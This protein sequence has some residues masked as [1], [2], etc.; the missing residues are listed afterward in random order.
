[1]SKKILIDE[2]QVDL[3]KRRVYFQGTEVSIRPKSFELLNLLL[4]SPKEVV[5]KEKI[6]STI[7][8]DV[9]VDEQVIFQSIKELRKAFS[10]IDAIKTFPRKGYAWVAETSI[11]NEL[12]SEKKSQ[13]QESNLLK[14]EPAKPEL[15]NAKLLMI[16]LLGIVLLSL[17]I[18]NF[19][20]SNTK[21]NKES[22]ID[23]SIIVLPVK[24]H[25]NDRDHKWVRVGAMDLL[26]QQI[27][28][29][30]NYGVMQVDDVLEIMQRADLSLS[31]FDPLQVD[32]IFQVSGAE[33]IIETEISG[34]PGD[35][36]LIYSL[37]RR[38]SIDRGVLITSDIY[39]AIDQLA[40]IVTKRLGTTASAIKVSRNKL[41][42]QLLAQALD[43]KNE[44][45][46]LEAEQY[47]QSLL[48]IEPVNFQANRMLAEV[49]VYLK[50]TQQISN[51]VLSVESLLGSFS[52]NDSQDNVQE[53]SRQ[54]EYGRL[55]FWQGLNELQFQR[56]DNAKKILDEAH[57]IITKAQDW[58]YLGHI[59]EAQ[60]HLHRTLK[61][62]SVAEDYYKAAIRNH[63]IIKC[64][65]GE[66]NNI[67]N[68]AENAFLQ[69]DYVKA[70]R[71]V[72][73]ALKLANVRELTHLL[74]KTKLVA[75]KYSLSDDITKD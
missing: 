64:P 10:A 24:E 70:K 30:K 35:Y 74:E 13:L 73:N 48:A 43:K 54:R 16:V 28:P 72:T 52:S 68:L 25:L 32:K 15:I 29:S 8:D 14:S 22:K 50:N 27:P 66:G 67:L 23:G 19:S 31:S 26:I 38:Q 17:F 7:W 58:L 20:N 44:E 65:Y 34:A 69:S 60:G 55:K 4:Q 12:S 37:R 62:Y 53:E 57:D 2:Y 6:L 11:V 33:L 49:S 21:G 3:L 39:D 63:Q 45:N 5:S 18:F 47:L 61:Q 71:Q 56:T 59:A 51:I 36:Q 75:E 46:F 42:N 40:Q 9:N 1:M 41:V